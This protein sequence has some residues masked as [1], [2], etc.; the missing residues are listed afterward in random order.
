MNRDIDD[1]LFSRV[2]EVFPKSIAT[3]RVSHFIARAPPSDVVEDRRTPRQD[4]KD[5]PALG[6][7]LV[8]TNQMADVAIKLTQQVLQSCED[9]P[10]FG[11][12]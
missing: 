11:N 12:F 3:R 8:V 5:K 9:V 7:V 10:T 1:P 2:H 4:S 6:V